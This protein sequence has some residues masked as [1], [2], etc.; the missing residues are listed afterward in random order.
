MSNS[1]YY[2]NDGLDFP[3]F[4]LTKCSSSRNFR[5]LNEEQGTSH[6]RLHPISIVLDTNINQFVTDVDTCFHC[7]TD[8]LAKE[9]ISKEV[10]WF[11]PSG[12]I[13]S[14]KHSWDFEAGF[15]YLAMNVI[16]VRKMIIKSTLKRGWK[17]IQG[18]S[19]I[20]HFLIHEF[21]QSLIKY[22][23]CGYNSST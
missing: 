13:Y 16:R 3:I 8:Q 10:G 23:S 5:W 11:F 17:G 18:L 6:S 12:K 15:Q 21:L 14:R 7:L 2:L 4:I 20:T 1:K 22:L 19:K 9:S